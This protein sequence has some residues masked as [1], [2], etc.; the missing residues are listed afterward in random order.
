MRKAITIFATLLFSLLVFAAAPQTPGRQSIFAHNDYLKPE[1]FQA[2]YEH[3]VGYIEVDVFL[4][5][6]TL[7]VAHTR[8]EIINSRDIESMYLMPLGKKVRENNGLAYPDSTLSL[9][10]MVDLKTE[11]K[12]TLDKLVEV[13]KNYRDILTCRNLFITVSGN[14]PE[15]ST[16]EDIPSF[17]HFDG[18]PTITYTAEQ[19]S[20]VRL[21]SSSFRDYS[22][23]N[24]K[25]QLPAS[26]REALEQA[27]SLAHGL[28]KPVRFWATPDVP[29]AWTTMSQ[30]G[31][32]IINTDDV[33]GVLNWMGL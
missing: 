21:I 19:L 29:S 14:M 31:V 1:P 25:Q 10:L 7:M 5:S 15:P 22:R 11:G 6:G 32:D 8:I 16:W 24:G 13:L 17:I 4:S 33:R 20:R 3:G 27:I 26:D 23:W 18:R 28:G 2:A 9:T 12:A 30:L